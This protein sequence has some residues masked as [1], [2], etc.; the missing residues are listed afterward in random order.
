MFLHLCVIL[1]TGGVSVPGGLCPG[2]VSVQGSLCGHTHPTGMHSCLLCVYFF[3]FKDN[4]KKF[5]N[6]SEF[7]ITLG[8]CRRYLQI[9]IEKV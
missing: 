1:F 8:S 4:S 2:G 7:T 9:K 3:T 5:R 6:F